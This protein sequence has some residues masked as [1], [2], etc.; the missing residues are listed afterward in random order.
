MPEW[1]ISAGLNANG[2]QYG[3]KFVLNGVTYSVKEVATDPVRLMQ[4]ILS[5]YTI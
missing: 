2:P 1:S 3:D 5:C 4:W